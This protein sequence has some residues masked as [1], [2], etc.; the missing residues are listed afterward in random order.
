MKKEKNTPGNGMLQ[1]AGLGYRLFILYVRLFYKYLYFRKIHLLNLENIPA[2]APLMIVSNHQN[3]ACDVLSILLFLRRKNKRRKVRSVTRGDVMVHPAGNALMRW[4]GIMPAY[5]IDFEGIDSL[6]KNAPML[7]MLEQELVNDGAVILFPEANHQTKRWF[8]WFSPRYLFILFEAA[9]KCGFE[10]EMYVLPA[11]NHYN[12][13]AGVQDTTLLKYG[14]PIALSPWYE[15]YGTK[16]KTVVREVNELVKR[17]IT[18]MML[19]ITDLEHYEAIDFLRNT[20]GVRYARL[21][22]LDPNHLPDKLTAD[23]QLFAKLEDVKARHPEA[24]EQVYADALRLKAKTVQFGIHRR[25]VEEKRLFLQVLWQGFAGIV[26]LPVFILSALFN[27]LIFG[28]PKAITSQL[29]D[30]NVHCT[31][32]IPAAVLVCIPLTFLLLFTLALVCTA[33]V[34]TGFLCIALCPLLGI[35]LC[36]Y[37]RAYG[38]WFNRVRFLLLSPVEKNEYLALRG[39]LFESLDSLLK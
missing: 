21:N 29:E 16:P 27:L 15:K 26:L 39:Q 14:T 1:Y 10:K 30:I 6:D 35:F 19:N 17:Q 36:F 18:E 37:C 32:H 24:V 12:S 22:G 4:L 20:Y 31:I 3:G 2:A 13:Y 8:G 34:L 11:C 33:S 25:N 23:K 7:E 9:R 28:I 5:R 38:R